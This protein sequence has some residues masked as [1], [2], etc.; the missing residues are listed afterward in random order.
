MMVIDRR[1]ER[2]KHRI[3]RRKVSKTG[4]RAHERFI[5]RSDNVFGTKAKRSQGFRGRTVRK[6]LKKHLS[7]ACHLIRFRP[8]VASDPD[9]IREA[10]EEKRVR[11]ALDPLSLNAERGEF[12]ELLGVVDP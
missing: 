6:K 3:A 9:G 10:P 8:V 4:D 11:H 5:N 7:P 2:K 1:V 12:L